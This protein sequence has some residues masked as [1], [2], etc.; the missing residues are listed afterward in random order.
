MN[1]IVCPVQYYAKKSPKAPALISTKRSL[2]YAELDQE[3]VH[4]SKYLQTFGITTGD[5]VG[6]LSH[7][8]LEAVAVFYALI[9]LGAVACFLS[10]RTPAKII[11]ENLEELECKLLLSTLKEI[12]GS[13]KIPI[14]KLNIIHLANKRPFRFKNVKKE[15]VVLPFK[16]EATVIYT[17]GSATQ[18][19]AA[20]HTIGNHVYSAESV[21]SHVD[22]TKG[23]RWLLSLP[24]YHISGMSII[25]RSFL[26]G[27]TIVVSEPATPLTD[28]LLQNKITH[29]SLVTSQLYTA[30]EHE[31]ALQILKKLK[32]I[33]LG[34]SYISDALIKKAIA[35][36]LPVYATY[37][38][39]EMSSQVAT[40]EKITDLTILGQ[41]KIL[42][43]RDVQIASDGEVLVKG[44][45]LFKGYLHNGKIQR[46]R[47]QKGWFHTNDIGSLSKEGFLTIRGRKDNMFV[48]GGENI[49][50]EEIELRLLQLG[51]ILRAVVVP[52]KH[53]RYG[54]RPVAFLKI[55][56][57]SDYTHQQILK[58]LSVHL[59]PFKIP[60]H[61]FYWPHDMESSALKVNR[62]I[63]KKLVK[64]NIDDLDRID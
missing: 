62:N 47:D 23:G 37:G 32:A 31:K 12:T 43:H 48:S 10:P 59:P 29:L 14:P 51:S 45:T 58:A 61:F 4:I 36:K 38:L 42:K 64:S 2:T 8:C 44:K 34:G 35:E 20:V 5:R 57:G 6:F 63:F 3:L 50:P 11:K 53:D 18:P 25:W 30:F 28:A 27:A 49:Q 46:S 21:N 16:Q 33:I 39:T 1:S 15:E 52:I 22:Y 55:L 13:P 26:A 56:P 19:K 60:D 24:I 54:F 7:N 17:S 9:R 40:T 41:S